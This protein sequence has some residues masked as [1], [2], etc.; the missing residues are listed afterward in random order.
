MTVV[1]SNHKYD[2]LSFF[3]LEEKYQRKARREFDWVEDIEESSGYFI[4]KKELYNLGCFMRYKD[5]LIDEKSGKKFCAHGVYSW[6]AFNGLAVAF[7]NNNEAVKVA[8]Y[9]S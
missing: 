9:Y 3:E 1:T 8:Y 4:Y 5:A 2:I 6:S 7:V